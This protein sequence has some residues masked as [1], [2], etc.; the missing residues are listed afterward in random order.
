MRPT[1]WPLLIGN[2]AKI[3]KKLYDGLMQRV[4]LSDKHKEEDS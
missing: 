4:R 1:I 3:S 2:E